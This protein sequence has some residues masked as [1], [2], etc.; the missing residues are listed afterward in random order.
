MTVTQLWVIGALCAVLAILWVRDLFSTITG[1]PI[2][3]SLSR[4]DQ[5]AEALGVVDSM[6]GE[7]EY[8]RKDGLL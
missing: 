7:L 3:E 2:D 8:M 1:E 6:K 4:E 5:E